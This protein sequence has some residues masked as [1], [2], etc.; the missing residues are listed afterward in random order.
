M[1]AVTYVGDQDARSRARKTIRKTGP[2]VILST[3][4][5]CL[6][7]SYFFERLK[8]DCIIVD[9]GHRLVLI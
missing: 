1:T 2:D 6:K 8:F 7:E 9:E 4:E 5:L 3:Y